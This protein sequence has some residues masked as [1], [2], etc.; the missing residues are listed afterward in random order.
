[1]QWFAAPLAQQSGLLKGIGLFVSITAAGF[2]MWLAFI[3]NRRNKH[4]T[5]S[6]TA[7]PT[8]VA[9]PAAP[10]DTLPSP[11]VLKQLLTQYGPSTTEQLASHIYV[12]EDRVQQLDLRLHEIPE[13][14]NSNGRWFFKDHL[15]RSIRR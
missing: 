14:A 1:M 8:P 3:L 11:A 13:L 2:Y 5:S 4:E 12:T 7:T 15:N 10:V 6:P 9:P